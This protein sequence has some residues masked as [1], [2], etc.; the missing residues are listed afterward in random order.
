MNFTA[1]RPVH[2]IVVHSSATQPIASIDAVD[3]KAWHLKQGWS[4]IGYHFVIP[5]DAKAQVGRALN[6]VGSH[7]RGHNAG[8]IGIC[9]VG[10]VGKDS[11]PTDNYLPAQKQALFTLIQSLRAAN[12]SITKVCGHRDLSPDLN[13]DGK[14][15]SNEWVKACPCFDAGAWYAA[16]LKARGL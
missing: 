9:M 2:T 12:P 5:V 1:G 8:T 13:K 6:L 10:G 4:D 3:I 7:V 11:K 14:I 16:E 15:T